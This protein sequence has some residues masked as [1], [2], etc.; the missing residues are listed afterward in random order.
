MATPQRKPAGPLAQRNGRPRDAA[1]LVITQSDGRSSRVLLG[2]RE[3]RDRFLPD[4]Y[5]FPGGRVDPGD[6]TRPAASELRAD[7]ARR[8]SR[9]WSPQRSRALAV[10]CVRETH[11]ET[12]LVLGEMIGGRLC[13]SLHHL[14]YVARAITPAG[15]PI[16]YHARFFSVDGAFV[17][18]NPISNGE[19]LDLEWRSFDASLELPMLD[20]TK[21]VLQTVARRLGHPAGEELPE[22]AA[23][24]IPLI[25]YRKTERHIRYE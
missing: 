12:S 17:K 15:N 24:E 13:P 1:S 6:A 16:R 18:G 7:V 14:D 22:C 25:H 11:E 8:M 21:F 23:D 2:R 9:H 19:L 5:V 10:A 4:L 3:P 20:V